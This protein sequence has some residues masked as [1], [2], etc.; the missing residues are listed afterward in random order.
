[1]KI[2]LAI[3]NLDSIWDMPDVHH[4]LQITNLI[5]YISLIFGAIW[6]RLGY[7]HVNLNIGLYINKKSGMI[8]HTRF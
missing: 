6:R 7:A 4:G 8:S 1:M 3:E 2:F 5:K